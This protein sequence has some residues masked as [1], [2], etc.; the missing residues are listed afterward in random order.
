MSPVATYVRT[1]VTCYRHL[2][3]TAA[4]RLARPLLVCLTVPLVGVIAAL[5]LFQA[6]AP[7]AKGPPPPKAET[8][9]GQPVIR[10][11][12][13]LLATDEPQTRPATAANLAGVR[14]RLEGPSEQTAPWQAALTAAGASVEGP[15]ADLVLTW[16]GQGWRVSSKEPIVALLAL[17]EL[18][19]AQAAMDRARSAQANWA[20][21][22]L[23][24]PEPAPEANGTARA[25]RVLLFFIGRYTIA[26]PLFFLLGLCGGG[27]CAEIERA[28]G[29][30]SLE[31]FAL[32]PVPFWIYLL[33]LALARSTVTVVAAVIFFAL[34]GLFLPTAHPWALVPLAG[35][36]FCLCTGLGML[37]SL[38]V[39]I[40]HH[41]W[42][43]FVGGFLLNPVALILPAAL[44]YMM[45][46]S[47]PP[48]LAVL[49]AQTLTALPVLGWSAST[50]WAA[51]AGAVA[52]GVGLAVASAWALEKRLG[53]RRTGLA[54]V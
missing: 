38:Q 6:I 1:L 46:V 10:A 44:L 31:P 40:F 48:S 17:P 24:S 25:E 41:R 30:G 47:E 4:R 51:G 20:Q 2:L 14:V 16:T 13:G 8:T 39:L 22:T 43:A 50:A 33:A 37:G 52:L 36:M 32:A 11:V 9:W 29:T 26:L 54:L 3:P 42:S 21:V 19:R 18:T 28:R 5:V 35:G 34:L 27:M 12:E 23:A 7:P 45:T 53:R 49:S 15:S